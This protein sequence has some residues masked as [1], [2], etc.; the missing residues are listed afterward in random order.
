MI[1]VNRVYMGHAVGFVRDATDEQTTYKRRYVPKTDER[2][3][4]RFCGRV[5]WSSFLDVPTKEA[6]VHLLLGID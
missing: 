1:G 4:K 2:E 6:L 5:I 3:E